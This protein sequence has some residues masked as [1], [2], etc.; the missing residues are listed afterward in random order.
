[1]GEPPKGRLLKK[2]SAVHNQIWEAEVPCQ[3][4][5]ASGLRGKAFRVSVDKHTAPVASK[6]SVRTGKDRTWGELKVE[7]DM[8]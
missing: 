7:L 2:A 1:M 5:R 4:P 3:R 6:V 8:L